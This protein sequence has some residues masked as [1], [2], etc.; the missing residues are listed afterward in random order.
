M[1]HRAKY[2]DAQYDAFMQRL[3]KLDRYDTCD[4]ERL[5]EL[6]LGIYAHPVDG[7]KRR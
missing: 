4:L 2:T 3:A 6:F 5:R 1:R 7:V